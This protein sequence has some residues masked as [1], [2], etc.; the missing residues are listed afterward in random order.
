MVGQELKRFD[1][2]TSIKRNVALLSAGLKDSGDTSGAKKW[3]SGGTV[4]QAFL[5]AASG[6]SVN[7]TIEAD[8]E[9]I[10]FI[11]GNAVLNCS[12]KCSVSS[13]RS[14]IVVDGSLS[15]ESNVTTLDSMGN[16]TGGQFFIGAMADSGLSNLSIDPNDPEP[17][18]ANK[19]GWVFVNP[20]ITNLDAFVFAQGPVVS[21]KSSENVL[22]AEQN[23]T[24][25]RLRNQLH[26]MGSLLSLNNIKGS[27][28]TPPECPYIVENCN[29]DIAQIF[30]LIYLRRFQESPLSFY[31]GNPADTVKVPYHPDGADRAK[32][33]GGMTWT[34]T[35]VPAE[36]LRTV[37]DPAYRPYPLIIERD[38]RWNSS[39]SALF[40]SV[41]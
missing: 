2:V 40:K 21:Y 36:G 16:Q 11:R 27:R 4:D 24:D 1:L 5:N 9:K 28:N 13:R 10:S 39:P 3:C 17:T 38:T 7:C 23:A 25:R 29:P 15:V 20:D 31:T 26:I 12:G 14:I 22:Y 37:T 8:G 35:T 6:P 30:D 33:S 34:N 18:A 41:N 32:R 19:K